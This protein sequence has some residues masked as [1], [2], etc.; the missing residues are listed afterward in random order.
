MA[1][2]STRMTVVENPTERF[3]Q[4]VSGV[5]DSRYVANDEVA[6]FFPFLDGEVLD[7]DMSRAFGRDASVDHVDGGFIVVVDDGGVGLG[8]T[9]FVEDHTEVFGL[10]GGKNGGKKF[11]FGGACGCDGLCF[12]AVGDGA[13][14]KGEGVSGSAASIAE[15]VG[16]SGIH[17]TSQVKRRRRFKKCW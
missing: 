7:V 2:C 4:I 17:V 16:V 9:K 6:S 10:F 11:G 1:H 8:K 14:A 5:E 3:C 15:V 13:A 12:A